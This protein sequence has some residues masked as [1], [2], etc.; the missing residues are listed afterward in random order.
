MR[1][2]FGIQFPFAKI[3]ICKV[4]PILFDDDKLY[5]NFEIVTDEV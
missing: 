2:L 3:P 5:G 1:I 4:F